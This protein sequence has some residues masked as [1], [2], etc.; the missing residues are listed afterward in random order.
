MMA[1]TGAPRTGLEVSEHVLHAIA[2]YS[3]NGSCGDVHVVCF[4][5]QGFKFGL[6]VGVPVGLYIF[7]AY[8]PEGLDYFVRKVCPSI[9]DLK[10]S[11]LHGHT[12]SVCL[13]QVQQRTCQRMPAAHVPC[14]VHSGNTVQLKY[15]T[16]PPAG[17]EGIAH[18]LQQEANRKNSSNDQ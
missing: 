11:N 10:P 4:A 5:I 16:Y 13:I 9:T 2:W 8:F 1:R 15:V 17:E 14:V 7:V 12:V 6:Y 3:R 18:K